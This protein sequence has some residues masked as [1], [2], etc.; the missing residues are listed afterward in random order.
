MAYSQRF[1]VRGFSREFSVIREIDA[2]GS[3]YV[4]RVT[5]Y[6]GKRVRSRVDGMS[7][8]IFVEYGLDGAR[9]MSLDLQE[10]ILKRHGLKADEVDLIN[11]DL[12]RG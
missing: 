6:R 3:S 1:S 8:G 9:Q 2:V 12:S 11:L 4:C 5:L 10:T 7:S